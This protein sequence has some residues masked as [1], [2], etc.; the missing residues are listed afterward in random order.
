MAR[1]DD[2]SEGER[3]MLKGLPLPSF[4]TTPFVRGKP[5]SHRSA[6][7]RYDVVP[8]MWWMAIVLRTGPAFKIDAK[9]PPEDLSI[10]QGTTSYRVHADRCGNGRKP[11]KSI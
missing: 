8:W 3:E 2:I 5:L 4:D 11:P 6:W 9:S 1:L 7:T 10:I